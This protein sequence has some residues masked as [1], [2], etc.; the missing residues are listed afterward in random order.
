MPRGREENGNPLQYSCLENFMDKRSLMGYSPWGHKESGMTGHAL[1]A[2][3]TRTVPW[4]WKQQGPA[5]TSRS[6][7]TSSP[8]PFGHQGPVSW[9]TD[10]GERD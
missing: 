6:D 3:R 5:T 10:K 1:Y 9:K 8:Q 7:L 4:G 2:Q